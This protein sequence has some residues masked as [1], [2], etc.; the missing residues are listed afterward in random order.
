MAESLLFGASLLNIFIAVWLVN[1]SLFPMTVS[2]FPLL[3]HKSQ[4]K[5]KY[6]LSCHFLQFHLG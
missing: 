5:W 6:Y 4:P 1:F 2:M 3:K